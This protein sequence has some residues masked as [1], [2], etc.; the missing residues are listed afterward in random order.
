VSR[1]GKILADIARLLDRQHRIVD[2]ARQAAA[3]ATPLPDKEWHEAMA[4]LASSARAKTNAVQPLPKSK[5]KRRGGAGRPPKL[6][7]VR[8]TELQAIYRRDFANDPR[9][10]EPGRAVRH[11]LKFLTKAERE[12]SETT[13]KRRVLRPVQHEQNKPAA[14]AK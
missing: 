8:A 4:E 1:K 6:T 10:R 9:L 7:E 12:I 5:R 2:A 13:L 14:R 3:K 11:M